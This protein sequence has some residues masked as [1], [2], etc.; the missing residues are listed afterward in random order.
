M[1]TPAVKAR[2]T[3]RRA[4]DGQH[5]GDHAGAGDRLLARGAEAHPVHDERVAAL[6]RDDGHGEH[7][8]AEHGYRRRLHPD[9]EAAEDTA[10]GLPPRQLPRP[11]RPGDAQHARADRRHHGHE[12]GE[13]HEAGAEAPHRSLEAVAKLHGQLSVDARLHRSEG[14][15]DEARRDGYRSRQRHQWKK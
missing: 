2:S 12:D 9:E 15:D 3:G 8:D 6:A 7:R 1:T 14:A 13:H 5:G 4:N 10:H 11:D